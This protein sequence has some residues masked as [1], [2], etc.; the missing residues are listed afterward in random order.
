M[1]Y[2]ARVNRIYRLLKY[3]ENVF[4]I[5]WQR[6]RFEVILQLDK[7]QVLCIL[8]SLRIGRQD[9][10]SKLSHISFGTNSYTFMLWSFLYSQ[11]GFIKEEE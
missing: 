3:L 4:E 7:E 2:A 11:L 10:A 5:W 9:Q 6:F 1:F 8:D